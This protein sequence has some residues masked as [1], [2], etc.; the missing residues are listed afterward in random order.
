MK[1]WWLCLPVVWHFL[2]QANSLLDFS[3]WPEPQKIAPVLS[4]LLRVRQAAG[5]LRGQVSFI[6]ENQQFMNTV[7]SVMVH[8]DLNFVFYRPTKR[9]LTGEK[10]E[11]PRVPAGHGVG[12]THGG[13]VL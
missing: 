13:G 9:Q 8:M 5:L 11:A 12:H 3:G 7:H 4:A 6:G 1:I 10:P 2:Q